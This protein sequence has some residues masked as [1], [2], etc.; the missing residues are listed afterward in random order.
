MVLSSA[1]KWQ[2][3]FECVLPAIRG[4]RSLF[5]SCCAIAIRDIQKRSIALCI[6]ATK[7]FTYQNKQTQN[8]FV[9]RQYLRYFSF[10]L[11]LG[12][13]YVLF[14]GFCAVVLSFWLLVAAQL[15]RTKSWSA[16][17]CYSY[18][19]NIKSLGRHTTII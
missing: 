8:T 9:K 13:Q 14:L 17:L 7:V 11:F 15:I 16:H 6:I 5:S 10:A 12:L 4:G 1:L 19:D 18:I 3:H 2:Y